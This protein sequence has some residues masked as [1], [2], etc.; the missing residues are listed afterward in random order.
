MKCDFVE[1]TAKTKLSYRNRS[2]SLFSRGLQKEVPQTDPLRVTPRPSKTIETSYC[3]RFS[4]FTDF[5][6]NMTNYFFAVPMPLDIKFWDG[7]Y[8]GCMC[9]HLQNC[10]ICEDVPISFHPAVSCKILGMRFKRAHIIHSE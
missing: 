5:T 6:Q 1:R 4:F 9:H 3:T 7:R 8:R 2:R 10:Q